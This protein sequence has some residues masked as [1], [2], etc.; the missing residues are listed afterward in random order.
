[1]MCVLNKHGEVYLII[2]LLDLS[3]IFFFVVGRG[4]LSFPGIYRS[5]VLEYKF[6]LLPRTEESSI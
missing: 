4:R 6:N 5:L 1:M 2:V 3:C